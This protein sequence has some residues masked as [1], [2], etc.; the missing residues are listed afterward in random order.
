MALEDISAENLRLGIIQFPLS[1]ILLRIFFLTQDF[2][3]CH[4]Q[5]WE[6]GKPH[7]HFVLYLSLNIFFLSSYLF[8]QFDRHLGLWSTF[9]VAY[10]EF[11]SPLRIYVGYFQMIYLL[12]VD[13]ELIEFW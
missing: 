1:F 8:P 7:G 12:S 11:F 5:F 13:V 4:F 2:C 3:R 9:N 6:L 10:A